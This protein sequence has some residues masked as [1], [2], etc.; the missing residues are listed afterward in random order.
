M[1]SC[2]HEKHL[3]NTHTYLKYEVKYKKLRIYQSLNSYCSC[4]NPLLS[5]IVEHVLDNH[6]SA[7]Y[8]SEC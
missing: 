7:F 4:Y 3:T 2:Y 6:G 1:N 5:I 8:E